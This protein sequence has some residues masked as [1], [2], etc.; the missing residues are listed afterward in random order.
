MCEDLVVLLTLAPLATSGLLISIPETQSI[1]LTPSGDGQAAAGQEQ[2]SGY[3]TTTDF[4]RCGNPSGSGTIQCPRA[5][6][7]DPV[8]V[9][10]PLIRG[11]TCD[12]KTSVPR[13]FLVDAYSTGLAPVPRPDNGWRL[14]NCVT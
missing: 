9:V 13:H 8:H 6:K 12:E 7:S 14:A 2:K 4:S 1:P 10:A 5:K 3:T 11:E